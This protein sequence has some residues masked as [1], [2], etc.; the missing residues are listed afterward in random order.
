VLALSGCGGGLSPLAREALPPAAAK[1]DRERVQVALDPARIR[2]EA[3]VNALTAHTL[4]IP[5]LGGTWSAPRGRLERSQI[6]LTLELGAATSQPQA[7]ANIA[8]SPHFLDAAVFPHGRIEGQ[9][10]RRRSASRVPGYE[11]F[12]ELELKNRRRH[13]SA[14]AALSRVGCEVRLNTTFSIDRREFGIARRG[15]YD[16]L[17]GDRIEVS[18][19]ASA[20]TAPFGVP[21]AAQSSDLAQRNPATAIRKLPG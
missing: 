6:E 17:V 19:E 8:K 7:I 4:S 14:P 5:A 2:V 9:W 20:P 16:A 18:V 15:R 1:L 12:F 11:L 3:R 21:C 13:L 10:L